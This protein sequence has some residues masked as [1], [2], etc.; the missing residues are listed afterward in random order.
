MD[1]GDAGA[2][3]FGKNPNKLAGEGDFGDEKDGGFLLFKGIFSQFKV[4]VSFTASGHAMKEFGV[5][6]SLL[7]LFKG[8]FLGGI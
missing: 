7:E 4:D 5:F 2:E 6:W 3:G 1:E 8:G